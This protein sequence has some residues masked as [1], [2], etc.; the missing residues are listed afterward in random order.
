MTVRQARSPAWA[1]A[2][3]F[4]GYAAGKAVYAA[5]GR[6][7]FPG[8]PAVSAAEH[9]R[10]AREMLDVA[11]TQWLA[12][13]NGLLG[14]VL[15]LATVTSVGRRLPRTPMLAVLGLAFL[16]LGAGAAIMVVD[17]FVGIGVGWRWYHGV[18]GIVAVVLLAATIRSYARATAPGAPPTRRPG[19]TSSPL[20]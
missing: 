19:A 7:G 17:G 2:V 14:A 9:E 10:Y 20:P 1:T 4:L 15:M 12:A 3:L 18:L 16:G 13:A 6:L 11:A 5:Q 8:G